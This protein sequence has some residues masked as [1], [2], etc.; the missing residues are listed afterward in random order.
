[1]SRILIIRNRKRKALTAMGLIAIWLAFTP[2]WALSLLYFV[3]VI[4]LYVNRIVLHKANKIPNLSAKRDIRTYDC[5][6]IGDMCRMDIPERYGIPINRTFFLTAPGRSLEASF[7]LL[8]HTFSLLNGQ[9]RTCII[10]HSGKYKTIFSVFDTPYISLVSRKE[11]GLEKLHARSSY[12]LFFDPIRS[13]R[14]LLSVTPKK[15]EESDC[16]DERI[17]RLCNDKGMRLIYLKCQ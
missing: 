14:A 16:P 5:L 8:S 2:L 11:L 1:M 9:Q 7:N 12:P 13:I 15:Y 3:S 6:V 10:V 17:K 4:C